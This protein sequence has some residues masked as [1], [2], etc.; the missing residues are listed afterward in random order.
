MTTSDSAPEPAPTMYS[1]VVSM[2][3]GPFDLVIDFGFKSPEDVDAQQ[4]GKGDSWDPVARIAMSHAHAKS[5]LPIL[6]RLIS[7]FEKSQ[8]T[9]PAP[10]FDEH[11]KG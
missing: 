2:H 5:M 11:N 6:A 8:G 9:I 7:E 3:L 1:N 4:R 10:G